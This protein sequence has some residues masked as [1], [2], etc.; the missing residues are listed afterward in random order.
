MEDIQR[1]E[2]FR[3]LIRTMRWSYSRIKSYEQCPYGWYLHYLL[4][5]NVPGEEKFYASFGSFVHSLIE[6]Y[7]RGELKE[8]E[9]PIQYLIHYMAEVKGELPSGGVAERY[10][11]DG[12][13]YFSS[14]QPFP[15]QQLGVEERAE[16]QIGGKPFLGFIDYLGEKDGEIYLVDNKARDLKPR[17]KRA[18]PT[19]ND[20]TLDDMLRQLYLYSVYVKEKY[21]VF[22]KELCF[23]CYRTGTFIREPFREEKYEEAKS[24][25]VN[26]ISAIEET[27]GFPPNRNYFFCKWLCGESGRCKYYLRGD[28]DSLQTQM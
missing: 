19:G 10:I 24:W 7:Y 9:L 12:A 18:K 20:K 26:N 3:P 13:R 8:A 5:P 11:G 23:N 16:F 6:R 14:F 15:F 17:S 28:D 1:A 21:G 4:F 25:A 2:L 27:Q 22:P